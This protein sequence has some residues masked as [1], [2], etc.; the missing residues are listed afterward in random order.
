[1]TDLGLIFLSI[2]AQNWKKMCNFAL[3]IRKERKT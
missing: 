1:M 2:T 3:A